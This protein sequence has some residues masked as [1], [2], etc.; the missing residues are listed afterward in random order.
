M[1]FQSLVHSRGPQPEQD[2]FL[3]RVDSIC[4]Y[5]RDLREKIL[6]YGTN[7]L[8]CAKHAANF[9]YTVLIASCE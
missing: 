8:F 3:I 9:L 5:L 6:D 1:T 2:N 4:E 7:I